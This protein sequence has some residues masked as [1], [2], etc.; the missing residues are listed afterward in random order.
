MVRLGEVWTSD[1]G[2]LHWWFEDKSYA[3]PV[4]FLSRPDSN[5]T[6][7][8]AETDRVKQH[9]WRPINRK[10]AGDREPDPAAFLRRHRHHVR[11]VPMIAPRLDG[12]C[13]RKGLSRMKPSAL[14]LDG[15][16]LADLGSLPDRLLGW[17]AVLPRDVEWLGKWPIRLAGG[18]RALIP[19]EGPP[20]PLKTS[21]LTVLSMVYKMWAGVHLADTI[22]WHKTW[23]HAAAFGCR[24]AMSALDRAAFTH[25]FLELCRLWRWIVAGM[26][27]EYV[28][29][30]DLIP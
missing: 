3:P 5:A 24:P 1:R 25:A 11:Q 22:A 9:A 16:S 19:K 23:A 30:F 8:V 20:G 14:G 12:C 6:A 18:Y 10:C 4:T 29:C 7:N 17:L 15:W 26:S 27:V 28:K 2:A 21:L 13:V